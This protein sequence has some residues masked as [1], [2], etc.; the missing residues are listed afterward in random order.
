MNPTRD[1]GRLSLPHLA[2]RNYGNQAI[3]ICVTVNV[4]KRRQLLANDEAVSATVAAWKKADHWS[5]G[6]YVFMPDHIHLFCAPVVTT[7]PFKRWMEFWRA[8]A[9]RH[10]PRP[11]EKPVWQRDFFDRQLRHD[12]S[13]TQKWIYVWEN[14]VKAG[15]V[16]RAEDWPWKGELNV[17][18]W[19]EP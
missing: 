9:T 1:P 15:L 3:V 7:T 10:W 16:Q 4:D 2:P 18:Q 14:P 17:L 6:R 11:E 12:E 19:H 13:Y 5:V 8:E